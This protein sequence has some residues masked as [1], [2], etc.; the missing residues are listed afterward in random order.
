MEIRPREIVI[1]ACDYD[2]LVAWYCDVLGFE[3]VREVT[4]AF[5]HANLKSSGGVR[6]GIADA[7]EMGVPLEMQD[8]T[9][10]AQSVVPQIEVTDVTAFLHHVERDGGRITGGPSLDKDDG[11]WFGSFADPQGNQWWV[12]DGKCP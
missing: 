5:H 1:M 10:D 6:I 12:V 9:S 8:G 2:A 3:R 4:D 11:F 7:K